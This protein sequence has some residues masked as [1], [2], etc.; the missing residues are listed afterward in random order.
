MG[1]FE[2]VHT[3]PGEDRSAAA[4][5]ALAVFDRMGMPAPRQI[6]VKDYLLAVY[7]K[8]EASEP[9]LQEFG[10]GDFA[11]ACGTLIYEKMVGKEAATA[12]YRDRS[13]RYLP[14][15]RALGHYAVI[16]RKAGQ[17]E[18]IP[19]ILGGLLVFYDA[20]RRI[21]SSSFLAVAS[22]LDRVTLGTQGAC[23]YVFNGV[24][25][26]NATIFDEVLLAPVNAT[27]VVGQQ[28]LEIKSHPVAIPTTV[29]T[30]PFE[31]TVEHSMEH[32]DR[33]FTAV[34]ATFGNRVTCALSGGYDSRL[35]LA[36]LRR[37]GM[38]PRVYVYGPPG[39]K[40]VCLARAIAEGEGFALEVV[41]KE[42]QFPITPNEF[43]S[44]VYDNFLGSD[45]YTWSSIFTNCAE[46]VQRASRVSGNALALNGGGGEIWRN[47]FYL[48]DRT[49]SPRE[50]LW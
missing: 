26:G 49:Y 18:I 48:P 50:I 19:D 2:L 43:G 38:N 23:E 22:A 39:A 47:F 36:L 32:L 17:T 33:Y 1:G 12:F 20:S 27:I 25:S 10:D 21:A 11:F 9:S 4:A 31:A 45:G 24:V 40:D 3:P 34:T 35:I 30:E 15:D 46:R 37:H 44:V 28:G 16:L 7:P 13:G 14:R 42:R 41:D 6:R 29:S 8:R 5:A